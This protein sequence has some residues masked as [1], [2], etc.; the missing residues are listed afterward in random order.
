MALRLSRSVTLNDVTWGVL[1]PPFVYPGSTLPEPL[2]L[3][4]LLLSIAFSRP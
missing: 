1:I 2:V 4:S 3:E